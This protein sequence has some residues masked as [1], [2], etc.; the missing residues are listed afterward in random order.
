[1]GD[2]LWFTL[3]DNP[4]YA[5]NEI[6]IIDTDGHIGPRQR[7]HCLVEEEGLIVFDIL[8]HNNIF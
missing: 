8:F 5:L 2:R 1:M 7:V 3:F 6:S 4:I